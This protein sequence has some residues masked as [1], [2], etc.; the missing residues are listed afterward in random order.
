MELLAQFIVT[1]IT[2]G[3][4]Y[5]L[6]G[7]AMVIIYKSC[8]IF[9]FA[10]GSIVGFV[11]LLIWAFWVQLHL[12]VWLVLIAIILSSIILGLII[13]RGILRPLTGQPLLAAIMATIGLG[14]MF[15][16]VVT[17]FWPGQGRQYPA[18]F[19]SQMG[20]LH[21]GNVVMSFESI[22]VAVISIIS[23]GLFMLF[24]RYSNVG[25]AMRGIA[26][27]QQLAQSGGIKVTRMFALAWIIAILMCCIAGF[28]AGSMAAVDFPH[29]YALSMKAVPSVLVGGLESIIGAV[30]GGLTIGVLENIAGGYIDPFVQGGMQEVAPWIIV[31]VIMII[32]PFGFFGYRRIERM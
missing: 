6:M 11:A 10:H 23:V 19:S 20:V 27:D 28:L 2:T 13:E 12:P 8:G 21:L 9:N 1:G 14:E 32:R 26:E 5:G 4:L 17:L 30:I 22:I 16:G 29:I 7:L 31:L 25:L 24:Y 18:V 3:I 15:A